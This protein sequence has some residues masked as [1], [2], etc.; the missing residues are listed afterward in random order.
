MKLITSF[1]AGLAGKHCWAICQNPTGRL[2]SLCFLAALAAVASA[3]PI[4]IITPNDPAIEVFGHASPP[5]P[6][7]LRKTKIG[8]VRPAVNAHDWTAWSPSLMDAQPPHHGQRRP[9]HGHHELPEWMSRILAPSRHRH[10]HHSGIVITTHAIRPDGSM[11]EEKDMS[12]YIMGFG[13]SEAVE[14]DGVRPDREWHHAGEHHG[15]RA[16]WKGR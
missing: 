7:T 13:N 5:H 4:R 11:A 15:R 14:L 16:C 9:H 8:T 2:T 12:P 6:P 10:A 3:E 1:A